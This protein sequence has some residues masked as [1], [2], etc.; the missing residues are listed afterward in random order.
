MLNAIA[1]AASAVEPEIIIFKLKWID[2]SNCGKLKRNDSAAPLQVISRLLRVAK[3]RNVKF[4]FAGITGCSPLTVSIL[5][6]GMRSNESCAMSA[7]WQYRIIPE[8]V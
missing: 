6:F 2:C 3:L 7:Q 5:N 4:S 8:V 1:G